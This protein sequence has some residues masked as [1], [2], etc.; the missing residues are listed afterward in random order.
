MEEEYKGS[1]AVLHSLVVLILRKL[2]SLIKLAYEVKFST[3]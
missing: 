3:L 2:E 1:E